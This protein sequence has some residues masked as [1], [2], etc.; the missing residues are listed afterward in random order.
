[1]LCCVLVDCHA[2][3]IFFICYAELI[4]LQKIMKAVIS[5]P[6][7]VDIKSST[8]SCIFTY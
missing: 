7:T 5:A 2:E 4:G 6:V 3:K 1:M 8:S